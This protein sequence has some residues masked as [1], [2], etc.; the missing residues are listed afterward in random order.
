M[1]EMYGNAGAPIRLEYYRVVILLEV[2]S[3]RGIMLRS[4]GGCVVTFITLAQAT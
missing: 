4:G 1:R 2:R 3:E